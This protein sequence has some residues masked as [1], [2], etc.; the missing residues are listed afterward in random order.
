MRFIRFYFQEQQLGY[1]A[2][3]GSVLTHLELESYTVAFFWVPYS[4]RNV[5]TK[6]DIFFSIN[7]TSWETE[8]ANSLVCFVFFFFLGIA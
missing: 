1:F 2:L 5:L 4:V 3:F 7:L 8:S 6:F